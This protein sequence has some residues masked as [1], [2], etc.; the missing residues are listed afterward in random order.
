VLEIDGRSF[1]QSL[2]ILDYLNDT[3][4]L[5]L[6]PADAAQAA[7]VRAI[8]HTVAVDVHPVCNLG[9]ISHVAA[10]MPENKSAREE[11][12]QRF[13]PPGLR[14][15]EALLATHSQTPF[16][17]GNAPGLADICLMPQIYNAER[18]GIDYSDCPRIIGV[19]AACN[20][21]EAFVAAHPDRVK[22]A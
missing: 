22:P 8:A 19:V 11:W 14:A 9:V 13:I 18:W 16:C 3:R 4:A 10:Q 5:D 20:A 21:H 7:H 2:A 1:T 12:M 6:V 17:V 15:F